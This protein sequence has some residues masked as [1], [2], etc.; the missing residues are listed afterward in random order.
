VRLTGLA[1]DTSMY[2]AWARAVVEHA[3]DGPWERRYAT[4]SAFLRGMGRGRV[5]GVHGVAAIERELG[6]LVVEAKLP[7]VGAP[8]SD[9]YEGDG[10]VLVRHEQ[11]S[12]VREAMK[13]VV[14]NVRVQYA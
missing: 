5:L 2:R 10:Y 3:F 13:R 12:V 6:H 4:G 11:T 1:H 9:S 7:T 8:K 14:A